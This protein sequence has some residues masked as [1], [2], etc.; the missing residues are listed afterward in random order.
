M[1]MWFEGAEEGG[2]DPDAV[3]EGWEA[4]DEV[5]GLMLLFVF[6]LEEVFDVFESGVS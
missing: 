3:E 6:I 4:E 1:R 5:F 2:G